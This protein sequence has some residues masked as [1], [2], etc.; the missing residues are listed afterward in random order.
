M[1][2]YRWHQADKYLK[3]TMNRNI[4]ISYDPST[5][6][7]QAVPASI[8]SIPLL[9]NTNILA[10]LIHTA[11]RTRPPFIKGFHLSD[12]WAWIRYI[13]AIDSNIDLQLREEW[14]ELDP[15]Q[16]MILSDDF[17]MGFTTQLLAEEMNVTS[18]ADTLHFIRVL[19]PFML[20]L[21]SSSR[22]G[23]TKSPDFIGL[24]G[25]NN[26]FVIECKGSQTSHAALF[27]S[28]RTGR[29]QKTHVGA[30]TRFRIHSSL[31]VGL[32]IPQ[33]R[34]RQQARIHI[35]DP[36][37]FD[38]DESFESITSNEIIRS[39]LHI[40][41]AKYFA[42]IEQYDL[43]NYLFDSSTSDLNRP[44]P[45]HIRK[46]LINLLDSGENEFST[47]TKDFDFTSSI[48]GN[49]YLPKSASI[50]IHSPKKLLEIM[51]NTKSVV[52]IFEMLSE[53]K[54]HKAWHTEEKVNS[55]TVMTP[56]GFE[57]ILSLILD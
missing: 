29:L 57:F 36:D 48:M 55:T 31:S 5:W 51:V 28:M 32:F 40:D 49:D 7:G 8:T 26:I 15:H 12:L 4:R 56:I 38:F 41:L 2:H 46:S 10:G 47:F 16:K 21:I 33:Y 11:L 22:R 20:S 27:R 30:R 25:S 3:E 54:L 53:Q 6:P 9:R 14:E 44:F 18:F 13:F 37:F 39:I 23:P 42:L 52:D 45:Q 43:V 19:H 34:S 17:G 50:H 24:D 35:M 1:L